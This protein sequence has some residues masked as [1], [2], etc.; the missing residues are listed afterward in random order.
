MR[1]PQATYRLQFN[2]FFNFNDAKNIVTYLSELGISDIYASP[3][4][5]ARTGSMHGYDFISSKELN[6]ELGSEED[7]EILSEEVK[8]NNMGWLQDIVPNHMACDSQNHMLMDILESGK[9][10]VYYNF[11]D[12]EW[13]HAYESIKGRLL[14]PFL[15]DYYSRVLENGE[16]TLKYDENGFSINYYSSRFPLYIESYYE[17]L[18]YKHNRLKKKMDKVN[19][20][21]T[22]F[23]GVLYMLK[24]LA[25]K[26]D[27]EER[28]D[29][30]KFVKNILWELYSTNDEIK[31]FI[32][33]NVELFNGNPEKKESF[34][35]LDKLLSDQLFRLS[36]WKVA[37]EE[38]NYR[39]FFCVNELISLRIKEKEVFENIHNLIFKLIEKG[40]IT[41][42]RIDHIDGLNDPKQYLTNLRNKLPETYLVS[43]KILE[44]KEHLPDDWDVQGTTGYDFMIYLNNLFCKSANEKKF[45]EIYQEFTDLKVD[46]EELVYNNKL[47]MIERY[48]T[49]DIDN[50]AHLLKKIANKYRHG[51]DI[52]LHGIKN[53][54]IEIMSLFPVYRTYA[55]AENFMDY[56]YTYVIETVKKA[57]EKNPSLFYEFNF[58]KHFLTY[59]VNDHLSEDEKSDRINF[60]MR[61]QQFTGPLMAKGFEDTFLY[62]YNR[63]IS[64]NEVGGKPEK[65]GI[66]PDDFHEYIHDRNLHWCHT[67]N[68][69]STH[70]TKRG[71]DVRARIN[72][73]SEIP[74]EWESK[75]KIWSELNK[76]YKK[77]AG[78]RK[79][80]DSNDEY[81]IYQAIIGSFPFYE[82]EYSDFINRTK[83]YI[84]KSIK[85]AKIY[86]GWIKPDLVYEEACTN[87]VEA[88]MTD[89]ESDFMKDMLNFQKKIAYYG[90]FNSLSQTLVKITCSGIAD[91]YQGSELWDLN[92]VDP[93]NRR[94]VDF[95]KRLVYLSDIKNKES[96]DSDNLIKQLIADKADGK[97]KLF[98]IYKLLQ[99]RKTFY[100][101]FENGKYVPLHAEGDFHDNIIAFARVARENICITVAPRFYTELLKEGED[102]FNEK[103]WGNTKLILPD[104]FPENW[105]NFITSET[106]K[107]KGKISL[108]SLFKKF[109]VSLLIGDTSY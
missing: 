86:T 64:L 35:L 104:D 107:D 68:A 2:K 60:I 55:S 4:L 14:I 89:R 69:T 51:N 7:F 16:I 108:N 28:F 9:N 103:A 41:G 45:T 31:K 82:T 10:S 61:F 83:E 20:D 105:K 5:K 71:E 8:K 78:R 98:L 23:L 27:L 99:A 81:L 42:L 19:T 1:I 33:K 38:I 85:E 12:I 74:E 43:E 67:M 29:Q 77:S 95:G 50:L 75:I 36:Y 88:I 39:R 79:Y 106:I 70:D 40:N 92:F 73:L 91:F 47:V 109:P 24:N 101:T 26:D 102:N 63:L 22:K 13:D 100:D 65:F 3:I 66:S 11:F 25:S 93:D 32:D 84:L 56:D 15:G 58:I 46:Y 59:D 30:V 17:I 62:I 49:G 72:V 48:M 37:N 97:I 57:I 18:S 52:T 34:D 87:F 76:K 44:F 53:A 96:D 21:Y 6:P 54:L 80:P 94:S 90:C